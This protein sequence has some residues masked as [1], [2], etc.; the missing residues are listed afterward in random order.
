MQ[1]GSAQAMHCAKLDLQAACPLLNTLKPCVSALQTAA[2][3]CPLSQTGGKVKLGAVLV[4]AMRVCHKVSTRYEQGT[5]HCFQEGSLPLSHM[6]KP[7]FTCRLLLVA[8]P[9]ACASRHTSHAS[10][11]KAGLQSLTQLL[12]SRGPRMS[13]HMAPL[14]CCPC[15]QTVLPA[16]AGEQMSASPPAPAS[17]VR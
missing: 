6:A 1:F 7:R 17:S 4:D 12:S 10:R 3:T 8:Q 5:A 15:R 9:M 14:K 16:L 2:K 11:A 13:Q